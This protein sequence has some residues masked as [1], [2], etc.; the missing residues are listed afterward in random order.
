MSETAHPDIEQPAGELERYEPPVPIT[1]FG[2]SD[3]TVALARM[4]ELA[5]SLVDVVRDRKLAVRISGR[6]HLTAEA[7]TTLGGM[8][9][10]VPVVEWT[11]KL[12][13][14]TGWEARVEARTLDG[15]LVG[16]AESMCSR[17]ETTWSKRDEYALRSMAQTRAISR[18]LRA[19]LGQ[20][21]VLA[22]YEPAGA[23]EIPPDE[24][25]PAEPVDKGRIP[26]ELRPDREQSDELRELLTRL[27][28]LD[29]GTDWPARARSIAGVPSDMVTRTIAALVL[30]QLRATAAEL[31]EPAS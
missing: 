4:S 30:D 31:E 6:E 23:D 26:P 14:G 25:A 28:Q 22:G 1:L 16:A 19:P 9:G 21:V 2:T 18:A 20:I 13:D 27:H 24:P 10:V 29:S 15:R 7:W 8:L 17:S 12:E 5:R 11:R 3:P